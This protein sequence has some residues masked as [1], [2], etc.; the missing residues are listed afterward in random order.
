M[1]AKAYSLII[2][3][4][5]EIREAVGQAPHISQV[6]ARGLFPSRAAFARALLAAK[7]VYGSERSVVRE[8]TNFGMDGWLDPR[9]VPGQVYVQTL[10]WR[11]DDPLIPWPPKDA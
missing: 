2:A 3:G 1:A 9:L 7:L 8:L 4:S 5:P 11:D 10:N 6:R